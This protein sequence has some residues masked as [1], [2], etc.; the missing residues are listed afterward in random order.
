M[1]RREWMTQAWHHKTYILNYERSAT[2]HVG[3]DQ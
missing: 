2:H 1:E 3:R